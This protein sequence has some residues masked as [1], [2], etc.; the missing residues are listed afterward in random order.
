[1]GAMRLLLSALLLATAAASAAPARSPVDAKWVDAGGVSIPAPPAEHPRL[2]LRARDLP[3]LER[4]TKTMAALWQELNALGKESPQIALEVDAVRYLLT[5]DAELGKRTAASA[6]AV[7][8]RAQF[9]PKGQDITRPI[10]R[11]MVTGAIVYDWCFAVLTAH[12]K[13]AF[14]AQ[15]VRLAKELECGYPP[16]EI[17]SVTGH[18]SEW[19]IMRDMI[20]AGLAIYDEYPEMYRLGAAQ[21]FRDFIAARNF[22][23]PGHAFHQGSSYAETRFVSDMYPL[24]I[25]DRLGA[26]NVFH[27]AQQFVPYQWI[28]MRRPDGQM[29]RSGDGQSR[30]PKLRSLLSASYYGDPYVMGDY[31]RNPGIDP[32]SKIFEFLWADPD[33]R[34]RPASELPLSRY[35]GGPYGWMVARSGWDENAVIAEMKV[36]V[37]NFVNHQHP[38][39]GAFQIYYKGPLAIDSGVY[40]GYG[41]THHANYHKRTIAHN[42]L[43]VYDPAEKFT[44]GRGDLRNDGGQRLVNN[45]REPNNIADLLKPENGHRTGTVLGR[46]FGPDPARPAYTYLKG[47]ISAAY[48]AKVKHAERSFVF[49]NLGGRVPAALVVFDRVVSADLGFRKHWLLHAMEEP[50]ISG[51]TATVA[52][53]ERGWTGRLVNRT[54]LPETAEIATVGGP[55]KEY[56]VFGEN[57][58]PDGAARLRAD[59]EAGAWRLEVSPKK[60]AEADWF[61]NVMQVM[62]RD[63]AALPVERL[64]SGE[65]AGVQVAGRVVWF[66]RTGARTD[67]PVSFQVH[68]EGNLQFLVADLAE[69]TW[70]VWRDGAVLHPALTVSGDAGTLW[71]EGPAGSYSLRR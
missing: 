69:G 37:Y 29:L 65:L 20:S 68:G 11:M 40:R 60:A 21:F 55:G 2:Y 1:M 50:A 34:P 16:R 7:L 31:L 38:D 41:S 32:M 59:E 24:W 22:W 10:G 48:S 42:T 64:A 61:L 27:P 51:D 33:L 28:Y 58:V 8:E 47:D 14:V 63:A 36:N 18:G 13:E 52:L 44:W 35:F 26:G 57:Q 70:Q 49:L 39:A 66:N 23:Y 15:L 54:L 67:R 43:L 45:W 46:G 62:D 12:Q 17:G 56:Q 5:R 30:P 6:L 4:R 71:F 3:D 53:S 19:M 25:F 9:D